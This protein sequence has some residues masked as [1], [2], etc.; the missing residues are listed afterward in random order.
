MF[1]LNYYYF[2]ITNKSVDHFLGNKK[3]F[4]SNKIYFVFVTRWIIIANN[5]EIYFVFGYFLAKAGE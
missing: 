4:K 2:T 3:N 5:N 1:V